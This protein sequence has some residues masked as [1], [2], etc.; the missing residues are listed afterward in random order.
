MGQIWT[1]ATWSDAHDFLQKS[2]LG[3]QYA[4]LSKIQCNFSEARPRA[5]NLHARCFD[6]NWNGIKIKKWSKQCKTFSGVILC[7]IVAIKNIKLGILQI[8]RK[9]VL[10]MYPYYA[11]MCI[12]AWQ[13]MLQEEVFLF[14]PPKSHFPFSEHKKGRFYEATTKWLIQNATTPFFKNTRPS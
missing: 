1:T 13:T 3:S 6:N 10:I 8:F 4:I 14:A 11:Y 9:I 5:K 2:F 12:M 7:H